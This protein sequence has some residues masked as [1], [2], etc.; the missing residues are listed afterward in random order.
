MGGS[1][2]PLGAGHRPPKRGTAKPDRLPAAFCC[3]RV[4][5]A[6]GRLLRPGGHLIAT[7][8][9]SWPLHE[10]PRDF[11]SYSPHGLRYLCAQAS[12][13]VVE[14]QALA[15]TWTSLALLLSNALLRHRERSPR[16]VDAL[17][18]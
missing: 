13:E 1:A 8:P 12:V 17:S 6:S 11:F 7:T 14:V 15:G 5:G 9:F 16:A 2:R 3:A 4:R 18:V 10:E